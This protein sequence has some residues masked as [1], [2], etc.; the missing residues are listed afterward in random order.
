MSLD[1]NDNLY[2]ESKNFSKI[3][4]KVF[5]DENIYK[6]EMERIFSGPVWLFLGLEAEIPNPGDFI[7]NYAGEIPI[8]INRSKDNK[9]YAFVNRCAH[10][11]ATVVR[12]LRGNQKN[13]TCVYHRW[14]YNHKGELVGVPYQK[15]IKGKGGLPKKFNKKNHC[16]R[17]L[18]VNSYKGAIFGSLSANPEPLLDYL[19]PEIIKPLDRFFSKPIEV[20]GYMRQRIDGNWKTYFENLT[21]GIHAGLL[22]QLAVKMGLWG[23]TPEGGIILDRFGRHSHYYINYLKDSEYAGEYFKNKLELNDLKFCET[24]DEWSDDIS[25]DTI[26]IFPNVMFATVSNFL[27]TEQIRLVSPNEFELLS[28]VVGYKDD[29]PKLRKLR[30]YQ[31][32]WLGPAGYVALEDSEAGSLIQKA[33]KGQDKE[34]SYLGYGGHDAIKSSDNVLTETGVRGFWRYY[35]YLMDFGSTKDNLKYLDSI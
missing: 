25:T 19:G 14:C 35:C 27:M 21:D 7:T 23:N 4:I 9:I 8:V 32:S 16:L 15:G 31:V 24:I 20:L 1:H 5:S 17:K 33:I 12:E 3:P 22:H 2:W 11:S 10:R 6:R 18:K 26:S 28:I 34:H 13:H 30:Q 29:T